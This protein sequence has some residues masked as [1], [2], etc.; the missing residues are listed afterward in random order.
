MPVLNR[1]AEFHDD[2]TAWRRHLHAHPEL[3]FDTHETA[4]FVVD[5]LREFG[6]DEIHEGVGGPG[7]VAIIRGQGPGQ[8][9]GLRADM[10]A[11][12]ME[13]RRDLPHRSQNPGKMHACG[14]DGHTAMLLGAARY[15]AETRNFAGAV[16]L[17][18]QPAEEG[19]GGAG[20]MVDEGMMDR[21]DIARVFALH[22]W[23]GLAPGKMD[24]NYGPTMAGAD[25]F[26]IIVRG[27]GGHAAF[28]HDTIDPIAVA[29]QIVQSL[30]TI[31]ARNVDPREPAVLSVTKFQAGT[32][33]NIIPDHAELAGTVRIM[34]EDLRQD[35]HD[36]LQKIVAAV[37]EAHGATAEVDYEFGYPV[38]VNDDAAVDTALVAARDVL[39]A[40]NATL[41]HSPSMG[42]EDFGLMLKARPGAYVFLGAGDIPGLHHPDY[43][44][45]DEISPLGAS[46]FARLVETAQPVGR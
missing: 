41:D 36:R 18:F 12:P 8:T 31:V 9:I 26:E 10:D 29:A 28:P 43:D 24:M 45:N 46:F 16:A 40:D 23:P 42:A 11:L 35:M 3:L 34:R 19:G 44:F 32:A 39:G 14:H 2:M 27:Q 30:Q 25:R 13:E 6:V 22:N 5:K 15:L 17:I 21:F 33:F 37:A 7:V 1:I 4:A 38:V 20:V